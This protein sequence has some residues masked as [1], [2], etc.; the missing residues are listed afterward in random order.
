M[1]NTLTIRPDRGSVTPFWRRIPRFFLF[2][3]HPTVLVR[4]L[5]LAAL[6]GI[7]F[8]IM[9]SAMFLPLV[10]AAN[11]VAWVTLLRH[12]YV[13]LEQTSL[14]H[15]SPADYPKVIEANHKPYK[16]LAVFAIM[17]LV[18]GLVATL[19]G[20]VPALVAYGLVVLAMPASIMVVA[21]EDRIGAAVNPGKLAHVMFSVGWPY[22][23]LCFFLLMLSAGQG[24]LSQ[25]L[26]EL[27]MSSVRVLATDGYAGP[28]QLHAAT[29]AF[30]TRM[31]WV[32]LLLHVAAMYFTLIMFNMMG[33]VLYQFHDALGLDVRVEFDQQHGVRRA[34]PAGD[35]MALQIGQLVADGRLLDAVETAY[36]DQ[37]LNPQSIAAHD[38]YHRLLMQTDRT[39]RAL[40]HAK[41]FI[42]L[43]LRQGQ[44]RPAL[45]VLNDAL[46]LDDKFQPA[47]GLEAQQLA[48][49]AVAAR[50]P[51]LALAILQR[52]EMHHPGS[53][54]LPAIRLLSA[55]VLCE[56][57]R[58]DEQARQILQQVV[59]KYAGHPAHDEARNYL[60]LIDRLKQA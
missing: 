40:T 30:Q 47:D 16:Q 26:V 11:L 45:D 25:W 41:T 52:F 2:P 49:A 18:L 54:V 43:L 31:V 5:A 21:I 55:K 10:V 27:G 7:P 51:Q 50:Q 56:Q 13:V 17:G 42:S 20:E 15:L 3:A 48:R 57:L 53:D 32:M 44:S 37:R 34:S 6:G 14:G 36:E 9:N 35:E 38:R 22:L 8:A 46:R 4:V 19:L 39:Q 28:E 58:Q 59:E 60:Q 33:Y 23:V 24:V 12:A 29:Q 1:D